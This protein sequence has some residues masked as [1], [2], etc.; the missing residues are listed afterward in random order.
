MRLFVAVDIGDDTRAQLRA[1]RRALEQRLSAARRAPRVTWVADEA[2]HL[3]ARFIGEISDQTV[4]R[5]RAALQS[6]IAHPPYDLEFSGVG[7]FPNH[8]RPRAVW[9]GATRGQAETAH[10]VAEVN[11]RLDSL[12][13][14]GDDRPFRVHLTV[15]RVKESLPFD[16]AAAFAAIEAASTVS[17]VDHVTLYQSR[18]SPKGPTYTA[19][20][21]TPLVA[22][23]RE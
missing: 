20:C 22:S 10:V 17:R 13:G 16:W 3:T 21:V 11:A 4:E 12:V 23:G 18:T 7:A 15:G 9:I 6:P 8:R 14:P 1:V 19:L 2:A 5:V